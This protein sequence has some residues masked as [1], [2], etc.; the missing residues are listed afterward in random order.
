MIMY[1]HV[2]YL[3]SSSLFYVAEWES[4]AIYYNKVNFIQHKT[5]IIIIITD[6]V[7]GRGM[8]I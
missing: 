2:K 1:A 7:Y 5:I 3:S 8:Q 6:D 4:D